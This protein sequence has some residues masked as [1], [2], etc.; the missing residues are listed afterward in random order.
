MQETMVTRQGWRKDN[1][2]PG[3]ARGE[4][5]KNE[6]QGDRYRRT[7]DYLEMMCR[8]WYGSVCRQDL[9]SWGESVPESPSAAKPCDEQQQLH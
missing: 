8:C 1:V 9:F 6:Q 7:T 5:W 4:D 2:Q 3:P